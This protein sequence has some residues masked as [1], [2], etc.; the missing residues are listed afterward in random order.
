MMPSLIEKAIA[1]R[2]AEMSK[3]KKEIIKKPAAKKKKP[4]VTPK[5]TSVAPKKIDD[6]LMTTKKI[7]KDG[8]III[9]VGKQGTGKSYNS[10]TFGALG[11]TL[12][13]D[14]ESKSHV[15]YEEHFSAYDIEII[16]FRQTDNNYRLAKLKT[17]NAFA[18]NIPQWIK[19]L[20][21]GKYKVCI[22]ENCSI[23]RPYA[24]F[25]WLKRNPKRIK[26]QSYEWGE[27]E[28][29]VQD[30][31]YPFINLCREKGIIL[32]L[33]YGT[34]DLYL[35][36]VV[37][38]TTEDAKQWILG[39]SDYELWLE[40][41][42]KVYCLKHPYKPFWEYRAE[43]E[44]MSNY[45]FDNNFIDNEVT[46]KEYNQFKDDVLTSETSKKNQKKANLFAVK[47]S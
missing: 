1:K 30:L 27:I 31:L 23:F 39:E 21:T 9:I 29:I 43:G 28:E 44:Q 37:I 2:N 46:F 10:Q 47:K 38:G 36:E 20:E 25:E 13:L 24:K 8:K 35:N 19:K 14:S 42:Y 6:K 16:S 7:S 5:K 11:K 15:V 26:P 17:V 45:L 22:I 3:T 32:I 12:I 34:K 33:C 4:S 18:Q 41:D 40:W